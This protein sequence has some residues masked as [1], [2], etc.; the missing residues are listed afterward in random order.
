VQITKVKNKEIEKIN[1]SV[2]D[3]SRILQLLAIFSQ[4]DLKAIGNKSLIL[5]ETIIQNPVE[6][7][8]FLHSV[9][10]DPQ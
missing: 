3:F 1:I 6:L 4:L 10:A 7:G 5:D 9:A 8:R 2:M